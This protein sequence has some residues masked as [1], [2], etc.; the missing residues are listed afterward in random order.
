LKL[1]DPLEC[2]DISLATFDKIS[3]KFAIM[4]DLRTVKLDFREFAVDREITGLM[5]ND[6][7]V[8]FWLL[9]NRSGK[10]HGSAIGEAK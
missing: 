2:Q 10:V 5:G 3:E 8:R 4:F 1:L 7:A 6:D 9:Y